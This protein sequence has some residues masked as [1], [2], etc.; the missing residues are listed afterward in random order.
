[1]TLNAAFL[2]LLTFWL[3]LVLLVWWIA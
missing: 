1:M 3:A 2:W